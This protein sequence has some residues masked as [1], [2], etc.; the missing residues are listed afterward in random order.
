MGSIDGRG[1]LT[2]ITAKQVPGNP[3]TEYQ[4]KSIMTFKAHKVEENIKGK[5]TN[6]FF[7]VNTI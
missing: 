1:H 3:T 4:L 7:P 5:P 6:Y 2:N